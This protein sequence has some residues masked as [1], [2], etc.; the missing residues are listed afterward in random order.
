M[1]LW[2][3]WFSIPVEYNSTSIP[4]LI[5]LRVHPPVAPP[6]MCLEWPSYIEQQEGC[7]FSTPH[8]LDSRGGIEELDL[9][10]P[11]SAGSTG[12]P[13]VKCFLFPRPR[14]LQ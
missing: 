1:T 4:M 9:E 8:L 11:P 12:L 5:I 14:W 6:P 3:I 10:F 7:V 13:V 2:E